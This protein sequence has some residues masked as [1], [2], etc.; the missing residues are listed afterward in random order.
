VAVCTLTEASKYFFYLQFEAGPI[1]KP[2]T[3]EFTLTLQ[4]VSEAEAKRL[5]A[6]WD[7]WEHSQGED[8]LADVEEGP[9]PDAYP[10]ASEP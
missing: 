6:I 10:P 5:R 4:E 1:Y 2:S 3:R 8:A 9:H 7:F